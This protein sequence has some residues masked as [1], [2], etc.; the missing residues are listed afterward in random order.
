MASPERA[1]QAPTRRRRLVRAVAVVA[2]V[3]V[4]LPLALLAFVAMVD[5]NRA[6]PWLVERASGAV[7]RTVAIDGDLDVAWQWRRVDGDGTAWSPGLH[8]R[9]SGVRVANASW[10][11]VPSA[12]TFDR[13]EADLRAWPLLVRRIDL[14]T[15]R[16][17]GPRVDIER[18]DDGSDNWTFERAAGDAGGWS[19]VVGDVVL[20]AGAIDVRDAQRR[21]DVHATIEPL[22]EP[23]PFGAR[24]DG[25]DP[26]MRRD[27]I[28][29]VGKA[30]AQRL[31][32]AA[33]ERE[34]RRL[35]QGTAAKTPPYRFAFSAKGT[36]AGM[37]LAGKGRFGGVLALRRP[38]PFPLRAD[39]DVG[40]TQ[41]ALTGTVTDPASPDAVD[42]R[43]WISGRN[44][45]HLYDILGIALPKS[46]PYAT[47]GRLAGRFDPNRTM[48]R[49][50]DFTARVGGSDLA[51]TLTYRSGEPRPTLSGEVDSS[52]LRLRDLGAVVGAGSAEER[53][54]RGDR[55]AP[56][57]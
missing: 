40:S 9:A 26:S 4:L 57:A 28:R 13:I 38:E 42:M 24:V 48:L 31:R 52:L 49:Y 47:V 18:R 11:R 5:W 56:P 32:D 20:G 35:E 36:L 21:L 6:K 29:F 10:A 2:A 45:A 3:V 8:V 51:G 19:V 17:E 1:P 23:V 33:R 37:D 44:L 39:I 22:A 25:D 53:A 54:A 12:A 41:I 50:E 43:L 15:I 27:V 16:V 14:A 55:G 34:Q 46:P 7:G 30:A